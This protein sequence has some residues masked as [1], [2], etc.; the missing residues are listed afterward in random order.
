MAAAI[1]EALV[2]TYTLDES[3]LGGRPALSLLGIFGQSAGSISAILT[4]PNGNPVSSNISD[5]I[6]GIGDLVP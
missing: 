6:T 2:P 1:W 3:L 4:G 5:S